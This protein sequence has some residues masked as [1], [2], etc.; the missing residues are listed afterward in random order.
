MVNYNNSSN[1]NN[2][3]LTPYSREEYPNVEIFIQ[4]FNNCYADKSAAKKL[5]QFPLCLE[6]PVRNEFLNRITEPKLVQQMVVQQKLVQ[7]MVVQQ[8]LVQPMKSWG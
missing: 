5:T 6:K 4:L 7:Q 8:K 2:Y 1:G 3:H